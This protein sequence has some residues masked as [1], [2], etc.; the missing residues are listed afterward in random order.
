[1][2]NKRSVTCVENTI[3][4]DSDNS[5]EERT[6]S[7]QVQV[8]SVSGEATSNRIMQDIKGT[9]T[10]TIIPVWVSSTSEPEHEV[11]VYALL[12]TQSD[13]T[14]ILKETAEALTPR[15]SQFN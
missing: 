8:I 15:V 14:F 1:M 9:H 13:T 5:M 4:H 11:L 12:D 10:S 6:E 2:K 3:Q 7:A